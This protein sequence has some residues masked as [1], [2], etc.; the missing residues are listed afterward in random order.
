MSLP[1]RKGVTRADARVNFAGQL[2]NLRITPGEGAAFCHYFALVTGSR[3][4]NR[5][6]GYW[7]RGTTCF[8]RRDGE[9]LVT[10]EHLSMPS[11]M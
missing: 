6:S 2:H 10:H 4:T 3:S 9:W 8:A 11:S 5:T 1:L 7:L